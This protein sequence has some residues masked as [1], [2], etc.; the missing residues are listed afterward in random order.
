MAEP[1]L[2]FQFPEMDVLL[3]TEEKKTKRKMNK[4]NSRINKILCQDLVMS[5]LD[6]SSQ[7]ENSSQE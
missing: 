6:L 5:S 4:S 1:V 2:A 3:E 7:L